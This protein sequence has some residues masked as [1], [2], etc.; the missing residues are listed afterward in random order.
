MSAPGKMSTW[1]VVQIN[2]YY[3]IYN[4]TKKLY[5]AIRKNGQPILLEESD[6]QG[7]FVDV[8]NVGLS[9]LGGR[10]VSFADSETGVELI[11]EGERIF[12]Q[13][14]TQT[15]SPLPSALPAASVAPEVTPVVAEAIIPDDRVD[16]SKQ[17]RDTYAKAAATLP[18]PLPF[19]FT[20]SSIPSTA[21]SVERVPLE[22]VLAA[23][24]TA[25]RST[26]ARA[27]E[28][29]SLDSPL[30]ISE[31]LPAAVLLPVAPSAP[32]LEGVYVDLQ[33]SKGHG[34]RITDKPRWGPALE[35]YLSYDCNTCHR[36][37]IKTERDP[38][39]HCSSCGYDVCGEC[40][41]PA[42]ALAAAKREEED[43]VHAEAHR[44]LIESLETFTEKS[45]APPMTVPLIPEPVD[46]QVLLGGERVDES[47]EVQEAR[48]PRVESVGV[49]GTIVEESSESDTDSD[50]DSD[51]SLGAD[52]Q[53]LV[54]T[55]RLDQRALKRERAH[56]K[57]QEKAARKAAKRASKD[58]A[59]DARQSFETCIRGVKD[60]ARD[61][62]KSMRA[63][64]KAAERGLKAR[65]AHPT[66]APVATP[67]AAVPVQETP[68]TA[69]LAS[70]AVDGL[71]T[72]INV[73]AASRVEFTQ[74]DGSL[75]I[76]VIPL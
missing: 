36:K 48:S 23:D 56:A 26:L 41:E 50:S 71:V 33:C 51:V 11:F 22:E 57:T 12:R 39:A 7:I 68:R 49:V 30:D 31:S 74:Q 76:K 16:Y 44:Q 34:L 18:D 6:A 55:R 28:D 27:S 52:Q 19:I 13:I 4:P 32:A 58:V 29:L 2:Q 37:N 43:R 60:A 61:G 15:S 9:P 20:P 3:A 10:M 63:T 42:L 53:L 72:M 62:I 40:I 54:A 8:R 70:S 35:L 73:S 25:A 59:A 1:T 38:P 67:V 75:V 47:I 45:T 14:P 69:R 64:M 21:V 5:L 24:S 46:V 66:P 17:L 65:A